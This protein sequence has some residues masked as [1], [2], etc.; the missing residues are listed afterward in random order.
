MEQIQHITIEK[1]SRAT[2]N[3]LR[4]IGIEKDQRLRLMKEQWESGMNENVE[5]VRL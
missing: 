1:A 3:K 4:Q 2:L 5:V